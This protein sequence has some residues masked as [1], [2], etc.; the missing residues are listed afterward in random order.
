VL[1]GKST[2]E[3]RAAVGRGVGIQEELM[4]SAVGFLGQL[5]G[6]KAYFRHLRNIGF[7]FLFLCISSPLKS[8]KRALTQE[9]KTQSS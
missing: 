8:R 2:L 6:Q 5:F 1:T 9:R 3:F 4:V 7:F